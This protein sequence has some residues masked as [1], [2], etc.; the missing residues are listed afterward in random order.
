MAI[1]PMDGDEITERNN[2]HQ[3]VVEI[4]GHEVL[5]GLQ[6][7]PD[8]KDFLGKEANQ[9]KAVKRDRLGFV[10]LLVLPEFQE[11]REMMD[12]MA[13]LDLLDL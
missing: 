4:L 5:Q 11:K 9:V 7:L 12:A 8:H 2:S 10:V 3:M 6:D 1:R 13:K